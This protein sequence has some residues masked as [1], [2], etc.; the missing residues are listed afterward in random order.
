MVRRQRMQMGRPAPRRLGRSLPLP[1]DR[2]FITRRMLLAKTAVVGGF[3]ALIGRLGWMQIANQE[4]FKQQAQGNV[5]DYR[6]I[7]ADRGLIYDRHGRLLA[8]NETAFQ[9]RIVPG[10][11]PKAD[12][13]ERRL[14]LDTLIAEL[15]LPHVLVV[16]P[17]VIPEGE[18]DDVYARIARLRGRSEEQIPKAVEAMHAAAKINYVVLLEDNLSIDEAA[19]YREAAR[20]LPGL[21]VMNYIDYLLANA[22]AAMQRIVVKTDVPRETALRIE[23]NKL[24]LPGVEVDGSV[25]VRRYPAGP[26]MSH[27]LG[28]VGP[29]S[30]EEQKAEVNAAGNPIYQL[31]DYIGK[32]GLERA[33]ESILRGTKGG[34][35]VYVDPQ[36]QEIGV[37]SNSEN[38][39]RDPIPGS[40]I[41]LSID[42]ELQSAATRALRDYIAYSEAD[43]KAKGNDKGKVWPNSGAVV[44]MNPKNGEILAMVSFPQFD[45][46]LLAEGISERK[47]EELNDEKTGKPY[48]N[49][50]IASSQPPGSTLK[51]FLAAAGLERGVITPETTHTCTGAIFVPLPYNIADGNQYVCWHPGHG[52]LSLHEAIKTSCDIYFYNVGTPNQKDLWYHDYDKEARV[53]GD[54]H[55]FAGLGIEKIHEELTKKFWFGSTTDFILP[56]EMPGVVPNDEWKKENFQGDGWS[57]GDTIITSIGQGYFQATPLQIA[58]NTAA[59]ANGGKIYRPMVVLEEIEPAKPESG[60]TAEAGSQGKV[61]KHEPKV[62]REL[63]YKPQSLEPVRAGMRAVV[64]DY[65]GVDS[66]LNGSASYVWMPDLSYANPWPRTNPDGTPEEDIIYISGKTGTAEVPNGD[67][68]PNNDIDPETGAYYNQHAWFTCYAPFDDPEIVVTV[69]IEYGGEGAHYAAPVADIVL[70]AYFETTGRRKRGEV[71]NGRQ[72]GVLREDKQ[73]VLDIET[74]ES[75]AWFEPGATYNSTITVD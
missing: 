32:D 63:G 59:I 62:L 4:E 66:S 53:R 44:A 57:A 25:L 24:H 8:K 22:G 35:Q 2:L 14:V 1:A 40:S 26:I 29:I 39:N 68:D 72:V 54:R 33:M 18:R 27:L 7:K 74:A 55:E 47:W 67:N 49:R 3:A 50:A 13:P 69:L 36:G 20:G 43:R 34:R 42:L 5:V 15:K 30:E 6:T 12:T 11:L 31:D 46:A 23:A 51:C 28:F 48:F 61:K 64:H 65:Q 37:A 75:L 21:R 52:A 70:R 45:N 9:V 60:G 38:V 71:I 10:L 17:D 58:V 19:R 41:R 16:D 73:P 56:G